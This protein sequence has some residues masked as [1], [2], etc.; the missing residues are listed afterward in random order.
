MRKCKPKK[1][2]W[3]SNEFFPWNSTQVNC[4]PPCAI[5]Y[6]K[7]KQDTQLRRDIKAD[8]SIKRKE[9]K[10]RKE[11]LKSRSDWLKLAQKSCND[12]VRERDKDEPCISCQRCHTGQYHAGHYKSVGAYPELRFHPLNI[13]KQC[14]ACNDGNKLSGNIHEYRKHLIKKIG[15]ENVDWLEGPHEAQHL[16][17]DDIK[18]IRIYYNER[19]KMLK[20]NI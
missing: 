12:Y 19:L 9:I 11:K 7:H 3:C 10:Q 20:S 18:E 16:S 6:I 14:S 5:K 2:R 15:I 4:S 17:V 13:H 1:C 8:E